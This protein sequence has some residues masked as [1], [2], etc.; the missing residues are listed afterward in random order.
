[1]F[2]HDQM[3]HPGSIMIR[4]IIENSNGHSLKNLKILMYDEFSCVACYQDKSITRSSPMN[5]NTE[6]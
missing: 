3:G 4:R 1:M 2:W 5:V 6:I